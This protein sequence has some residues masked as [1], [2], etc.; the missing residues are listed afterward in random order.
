LFG[1]TNGFDYFKDLFK[2]DLVSHEWS[3]LQ[4]TGSDPEKRYKH[5][6]VF[7]PEQNSIIIAGGVNG[8]MRFGNVYQ[9]F[10]P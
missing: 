2:L 4:P 7:Q 5:C 8:Q 6:A 10:I 9:F 3:K 1:G